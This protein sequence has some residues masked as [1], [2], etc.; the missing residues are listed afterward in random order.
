MTGKSKYC[1]PWLIKIITTL[2][3]YDY[4]VKDESFF[5]QIK[6]Y[7]DF[8]SKYEEIT[9]ICLNKLQRYNYNF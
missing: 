3:V 2:M 7:I 5:M 4:I 1:P 6:K 9:A 8:L